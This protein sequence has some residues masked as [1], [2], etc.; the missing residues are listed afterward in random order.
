MSRHWLVIALLVP[1]SAASGQS[2]DAVVPVT[3]PHCAVTTPPADAG[4]AGTPGGFVMVFPRNAALSD[5]FTGCKILWVVDVDQFRRFATLYFVGGKVRIAVAHD[6]SDSSA[7]LAGACA[8]PEGKSLLPTKGRQIDDASCKGFVE[9][10]F[11]G[12]RL[13]T[14]PR[15]CLTSDK[16]AVCRAEPR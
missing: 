9:D 5:T 3:A 11:Y 14:W 7:A 2:L 15:S 1:V 16:A 10:S 13:A 12:L 4:I 8:F 6:V